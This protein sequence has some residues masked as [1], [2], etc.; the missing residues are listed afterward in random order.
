MSADESD[1]L[2]VL[3]RAQAAFDH[4]ASRPGSITAQPWTPELVRF[5]ALGVLLFAA[6]ALIVAAA[7][8]WRARSPAEQVLRVVGVVSILAF[9][10]LLLV[11]GYDNAQLTPIVGL[12]GAIAGYLLGKDSK[13]AVETRR[14]E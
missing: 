3:H 1:P 9:S 6:L 14:D 13:P 12:F 7:L 4:T 10:A 8:L 5:L 2:D 11:V